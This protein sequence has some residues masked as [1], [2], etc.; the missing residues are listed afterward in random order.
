MSTISATFYAVKCNRCGE[1]YLNSNDHSYF[2][3]EDYA[4]EDAREDDWV[5]LV[6]GDTTEDYCPSCVVMDETDEDGERFT[7]KP[8]IQ[9][10]GNG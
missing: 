7:V 1:V 8:P 3:S 4:R 2:D 6:N 9:G 5:E 10:G